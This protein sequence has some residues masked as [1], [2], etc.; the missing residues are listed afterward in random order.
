MVMGIR[1]CC[2]ITRGIHQWVIGDYKSAE[3]AFSSARELVGVKRENLEDLA[4]FFNKQ[5]TLFWVD[6][7][8]AR[9]PTLSGL[10]RAT[11]LLWEVS[12]PIE[13]EAATELK[14][15]RLTHKDWIIDLA[16][17][18]NGLTALRSLVEGYPFEKDCLAGIEPIFARNG[19]RRRI[20]IFTCIAEKLCVLRA[21]RRI[22]KSPEGI[23]IE[24]QRAWLRSLG[25]PRKRNTA[26]QGGH[27]EDVT[28]AG[29][30][31][32][33]QK[34]S[35]AGPD[36]VAILRGRGLG[37]KSIDVARELLRHVEQKAIP[38]RI[39]ISWDNFKYHRQRLYGHFGVHSRDA[40][41]RI[42]SGLPNMS[43]DTFLRQGPRAFAKKSAG[44]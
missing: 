40:L 34:A 32:S 42:L 30:L 29:M 7:E 12:S 44:S 27:D 10:A 23:P 14:A 28:F 39:E 18:R 21:L 4:F 15:N 3:K 43:V 38:G 2:A 13:R 36:P 6:R 19:I 24:R 26:P 25:M 41:R 5:F 20:S 9:L 33:K 35:A 31:T 17:L 8:I 22:C 37:L 16:N 1:C 11:R